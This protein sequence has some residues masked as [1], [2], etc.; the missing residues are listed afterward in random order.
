MR[1]HWNPTC[2]LLQGQQGSGTEAPAEAQGSRTKGS[3]ELAA[4]GH[5]P[6]QRRCVRNKEAS[7]EGQHPQRHRACGE[8]LRG[9]E[10]QE[11]TGKRGGQCLTWVQG[12]KGSGRARQGPC[13]C[14]QGLTASLQNAGPG[15][16]GPKETIL[17]PRVNWLLKTGQTFR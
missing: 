12:H 11:M 10:V 7:G 4:A 6:A 13:T 8:L 15:L 2:P 9:V 17:Q 5:R 1:S 16:S 3:H 14:A